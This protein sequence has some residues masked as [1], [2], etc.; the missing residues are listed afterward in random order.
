MKAKDT[1]TKIDVWQ[2][3]K[4]SDEQWWE[5]EASSIYIGFKL[6]LIIRKFLIGE[7]YPSGGMNEHMH[8]GYIGEIFKFL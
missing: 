3:S 5:I 2:I 1:K 4:V 6:L 8:R 7:K